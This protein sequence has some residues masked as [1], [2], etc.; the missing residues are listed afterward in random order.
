[1][2]MYSIIKLNV[3][4]FKTEIIRSNNSF[5]NALF[6]L[7]E[8]LSEN[9]KT[10]IIYRENENENENENRIYINNNNN[11]KYSRFTCYRRGLLYGKT[12]LFVY[13][14][15]SNPQIK[16]DFVDKED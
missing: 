10:E 15:L 14:I 6:E 9:H 4:N 3:Q 11:C 2:E 16:M 7:N 12:L 8:Y 1:M 5:E 13:E